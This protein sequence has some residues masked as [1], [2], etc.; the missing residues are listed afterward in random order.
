MLED[1]TLVGYDPCPAIKFEVSGVKL[2][3][4]AAVARN[5]GMAREEQLPWHL[6]ED[7]QRFKRLTTVIRS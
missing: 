1:F 6:S 4:I 2:A 7:L 3:I 5:R